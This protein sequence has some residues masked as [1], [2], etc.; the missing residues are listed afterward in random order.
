MKHFFVLTALAM[1]TTTASA[2]FLT[3]PDVV[4]ARGAR[5]LP[6]AAPWMDT[7]STIMTTT[8]TAMNVEDDDPTR[9]IPTYVQPRLP[10]KLALDVFCGNGDSTQEFYRR[11]PK[12]WKVIGVDTDP[13]KIAH[14]KEK[15]PS[16]L[17]LTASSLDVFS[18]ATFDKIQIHTG[19]LL[20][21][22]DHATLTRDLAR[23]LKPGGTLEV[24][25]F[26][27]SHKFVH[28]IQMLEDHLQKR[29][30]PGFGDTS[31][32]LNEYFQPVQGPTEIKNGVV[33]RVLTRK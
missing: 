26:C 11:L 6:V 2:A 3:L 32:L 9:W 18:P 14:A 28:E 10:P 27:R 21:V 5:H 7:M 31:L 25:D 30:F 16:L 12:D 20:F 17:F 15:H 29:Y 33:W 24:F 23:L 8:S 19:R 1:S 13:R 22:R 4:V